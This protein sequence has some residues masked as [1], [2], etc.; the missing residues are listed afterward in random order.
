LVASLAG[1][2]SAKAQVP[3]F[4]NPPEQVWSPPWQGPAP[5]QRDIYWDFSVNPV[6]GPSPNGTPG[7]QY[8]GTLDPVLKDSDVVG[9]GQ[10][11]ALQYFTS[12]NSP[13][14]VAG[15]GI[16]NTTGAT[17]TGTA[18]FLLDNTTTEGTKKIWIELTGQASSAQSFASIDTWA[19]G[20]VGVGGQVGPT[21]TLGS[22]LLLQDFGYVIPVNPL[23]E[24][25]DF[26]FS[27]APGG[28]DM[29][30]TLQIATQ[31]PDRAS[32]LA[33]LGLATLSLLACDLRRRMAKA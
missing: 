29:I 33:L 9:F 2:M 25:I 31:C 19:T 30:N 14:G 10:T 7:A 26:N 18:S 23:W 24:V 22:G 32:T 27:V 12:A 15:I 1:A 3:A 5:Y 21:E 8:A 13:D 6:G 16:E 11:S 4:V 28:Y 20:Q 17:L